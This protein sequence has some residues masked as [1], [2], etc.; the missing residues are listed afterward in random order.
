MAPTSAL[1]A[2]F[3]QPPVIIL[4]RPVLGAPLPPSPAPT[5]KPWLPSEAMR[6]PNYT[7]F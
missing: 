7:C 5:I 1:V 4:T 6:L 2:A 3:K